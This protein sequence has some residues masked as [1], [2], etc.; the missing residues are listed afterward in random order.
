MIK[1][2][3]CGIK[4]LCVTK[5]TD[6]DI[7]KGS[8]RSWN[9][10]LNQI[11]HDITTQVLFETQCPD[12]LSEVGIY[13]SNLYDV[14]NSDEWANLIKEEGY[15][16]FNKYNH[17]CLYDNDVPERIAKAQ[18]QMFS[19]MSK[20]EKF[21]YTA[22]FRAARKNWFNSLSDE[23]YKSY[24]NKLSISQKEYFRNM[25]PEQKIK[26]S[27]KNSSARLN[28]S[29]E[30][31]KAR[32]NKIQ[33]VYS[34]GKHSEL[35]ERYSKERQ[36]AGNPAAVRISIDGIIYNCIKDAVI[37]LGVTRSILNNRLKSE[38]YPT[39]MKLKGN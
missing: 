26:L 30:R 31:K 7:Y 13:Y 19:N 1:T 4:Y 29:E 32:K 28:T 39:Y 21:Q 3:N 8:G 6:F 27:K 12:K 2:S 37:E 10:H 36:G 33:D 38:K 24:C 20:E 23:E 14:V 16:S 35:F 25:S 18:I 15:K 34:T 22:K 5:R 17:W 11:G 9:E